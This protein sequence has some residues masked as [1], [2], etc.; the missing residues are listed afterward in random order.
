VRLHCIASW[1]RVSSALAF[2]CAQAKL[3]DMQEL[4]LIAEN[5]KVTPRCST[6]CARAHS[7]WVSCA[8]HR[9]DDQC[10]RGC[11]QERML[12]SAEGRANA[13]LSA[14]LEEVKGINAEFTET[15]Q[16]YREFRATTGLDS[17]HF[18]KG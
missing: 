9:R 8:L 7:G 3:L 2:V 4:R 6:S 1:R 11:V 13:T 17:A 18:V 5:D 10:F 15:A 16:M 14:A 12:I